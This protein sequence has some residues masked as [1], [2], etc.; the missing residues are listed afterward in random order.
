MY[1]TFLSSRRACFILM[2]LTCFI[3]NVYSQTIKLDPGKKKYFIEWDGKPFTKPLYD[4][5]IINTTMDRSAI[6]KAKDGYGLIFLGGKK[7]VTLLENNFRNII[8]LNADE[9]LV[10]KNEKYAIYRCLD[11]IKWDESS[12]DRASK[13]PVF[14][15]AEEYDYGKG[16][17]LHVRIYKR[18]GDDWE[19][20][21]Y[22][23]VWKDGL[24]YI[25]DYNSASHLKSKQGLL[26]DNIE[27]I[28]IDRSPFFKIY[29]NGKYGIAN[30]YGFADIEC[31]YDSIKIIRTMVPVTGYKDLRV[32]NDY[33]V[34]HAENK[35]YLTIVAEGS[36]FVSENFLIDSYFAE[37]NTFYFTENGEAK[38]MEEGKKIS[39]VYA[40]MYTDKFGSR[41][42]MK[43]GKYGI[44]KGE[45]E[46][47]PAEYESYPKSYENMSDIVYFFKT[48]K[49]YTLFSSS[50]KKIIHQ[51][52]EIT[53][54]TQTGVGLYVKR[55]NGKWYIL[56][57]NAFSYF[58]RPEIG[59][60]SIYEFRYPTRGILAYTE[61][62]IHHYDVSGTYNEITLPN[63]F[64]NIEYIPETKGFIYKINGKYGYTDKS[65][66]FPAIIEHLYI[67][68]DN[69]L[70]KTIFSTTLEGKE[71]LF[72]PDAFEK[73]DIIKSYVDCNS[74]Q[75]KGYNI[76]KESVT[77]FHKGQTMVRKERAFL[78]RDGEWFK[79]TTEVIPD[80]YET[81][82][83][84]KVNDC[85]SCSGSGKTAF[86]IK[87][88]NGKLIVQ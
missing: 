70:K 40:L 50:Q 6:V 7:P 78:W 42:V 47:L 46:I 80:H 85:N 34:L 81:K 8:H 68:I 59:Y 21:H 26:C 51:K 25:I 56:V 13:N 28:N 82:E 75:G 1:S 39:N 30:V 73:N 84:T 48:G 52:E 12:P 60:D 53:D 76:G 35:I 17:N 49:K 44:L 64:S 62:K 54:V 14:N 11:N 66:T 31:K 77:E 16:M 10:K 23:T 33:I 72:Y 45:K 87:A 36:S 19:N 67:G 58:N 37:G 88:V 63:G 41:L 4:T 38:R 22:G 9:F 74:C 61:G 15:S 24:A 32:A 65:H 18:Y 79:I 3:S 71:Y 57:N 20:W 69:K 2:L 43:N 27:L 29:K 5:I 83:Q 86:T 55:G